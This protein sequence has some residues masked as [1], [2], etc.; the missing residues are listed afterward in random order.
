MCS[1]SASHIKVKSELCLCNS[2]TI[3]YV[4]AWGLLLST[5]CVQLALADSSPPNPRRVRA[6]CAECSQ[7][8]VMIYLRSQSK[9][10][11]TAGCF[12][13]LIVGEAARGKPS[14]WSSFK[15]ETFFPD[16]LLIS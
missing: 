9:T 11:E 1:P 10:N 5:A 4:L 3:L 6:T 16:R 8:I 2:L 7:Q 14:A 13:V 15:Y 12:D